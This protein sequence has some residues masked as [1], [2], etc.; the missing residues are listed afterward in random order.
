MAVTWEKLAY[1]DD[2]ILKSLFDAQSVLAA[3]ADDTPV[4]LSVTEQ[5]LVGRLTGGDVAAIAIGIA[6]NNIVQIDDA[7]V[8]DNEFAKFTDAGLEGRA[9]ADV[10]GDL[11]AQAAA[12]FD[13]NGQDLANAGVIFLTEQAEAE[14][15]VEGKGQIWVDTATPN[16]LW[17]TNDAGTDTQLGLG[18]PH[19]L[20]DGSIISDSVADDVTRGSII[21]GNATPK[22]DE[23]VIG[24]VDTFLGSDGTDLSYRTAAQVMA[25]LSGEAAA[26]FDLGGQEL[27][28]FVVHTVADA[29]NRPT[30]VVGKMCWQTDTLA[31]YACTVAA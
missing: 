4:A 9:Y 17:F 6:D 2:V 13:M 25:S 23:L 31:L 3:T 30:A 27:Q 7:G 11:S 10:L 12:A 18:S 14:A 16:T 28:E 29:A 24:A 21:Y 1:E 20:L 5:T 22:W 8:A 15:D 26:A 19:A